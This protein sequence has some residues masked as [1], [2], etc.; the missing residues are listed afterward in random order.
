MVRSQAFCLVKDLG[1]GFLC[2][3]LRIDLD[4]M[5][6]IPRRGPAVI[7]ANHSGFAG[8]DAII[9]AHVI[10]RHS[11][12]EARIIAHHG[13]FDWSNRVRDLCFKFGLR[14]PHVSCAME[15]LRHGHLLIIFPEGEAGNFKSSL[16]RYQLQPFHSGF[17]RMALR[18]NAP[19]LS[20]LIIGAEETHL[21]IGNIN[22]S[23]WVPHL[24]VPLPLNL[25]PLPAKW[26]IKV[27]KPLKPKQGDDL[28]R[29]VD[30]IQKAMQQAL[31][32]EVR[33]REYIY[34]GI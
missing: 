8:F 7:I 30:A 25:L 20:C 1:L 19:I 26:K 9:L 34:I 23:R 33:N 27:L 22:L 18:A 13:F 16:F 3:Y 28:K 14:E 5:K 10:R 4:G 6:R 17:L 32:R 2:R 11:G 31:R 21:N 15:T 24:R 29:G 12:R